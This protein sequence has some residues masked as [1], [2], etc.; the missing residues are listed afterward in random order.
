[1]GE[2]GDQ[3]GI[4]KEVDDGEFLAVDVACCDESGRGDG[5]DGIGRMRGGGRRS[6]RAGYGSGR[7]GISCVCCCSCPCSYP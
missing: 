6:G 1:M 2:I 4:M 3:R 7:G 5:S